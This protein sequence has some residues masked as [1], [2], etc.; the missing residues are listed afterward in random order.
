M[1][2]AIVRQGC[3]EEEVSREAAAGSGE[4]GDGGD[5]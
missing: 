5:R 3:Q 4:V 2:E 1:R